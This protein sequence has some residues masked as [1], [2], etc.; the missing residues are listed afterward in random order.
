MRV[1]EKKNKKVNPVSAFLW[2]NKKRRAKNIYFILV[3]ILCI[4]AVGMGFINEK[5]D[6][7]STGDD[8]NNPAGS[9]ITQEVIYD[10]EELAIMD[11]INSAGSLNDYLYQWANNG[12]ELY[13]SKNVI[14]VLLVGLDSKNGL[15]YGGNSDSL[16][17]VSLNKKTEKI[18]MCSF[19]RDSWCYM[20]VSGR[21]RYA[22]I[23]SSYF[24][25]GPD[26]LIDTI[27]RNFKIDIDYYVAVD[28][29]SFRDIIDALGGITVEVQE[30]EANYI[31]RTN[32]D[33]HIEA[34]PA[35]HLTGKQALVFAR[36]RK[37]DYDSDVSRTRRQR[38]VITSLIQSAK[39]ASLSQLN[40]TLDALFAYVKTD[41]TKSQ[42]LS[43]AAQAITKGWL[44]YEITQFTL[45][46][47]EIFKTGYVGNA[48]V[49]FMDFPLA[50]QKVQTE[51]YG[52]SNIVL[53]DNRAKVFDFVTRFG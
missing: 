48:S 2:K 5:L 6:L 41:L 16:I 49:V 23:N 44:N 45:S 24:H 39:N 9:N 53:D 13:S 25:G 51:I 4:T 15:Q 22:K 27:E 20:N 29:S 37:S 8:I 1:K 38:Q 28:F 33:F 7:M 43:Y 42:I 26:G 18:S 10:E 31:N 40:N 32:P 17:L 21:E 3:M 52:E 35:V 50:A 34:G 47:S 46:D 14:N 30:Y 12:G 36:I 19:F 11:A